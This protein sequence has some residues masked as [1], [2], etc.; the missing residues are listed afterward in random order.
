[1]TIW[2]Y[3]RVSSVDQSLDIQMTA[4]RAAGC[5]KIRCEKISGTTRNGRRELESLLAE[6]WPGDTIVITRIDRLARSIVDLLTIV[7]ALKAKGVTLRAT[8][9]SIDPLTPA[10]RAF[11]SMLGIFAEFESALRAERQ[12]E[13]IAK[14]KAAG[15]YLDAGRPAIIDPEAVRRLDADGLGATEISRKLKIGRASVYRLL[16]AA[17]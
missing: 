17:P 13:G 3:A 6:V 8:E 9:Q 1:M 5:E 11:L 4:L 14:A 12:R 10:G 16:K 15:K 7:D 2:G